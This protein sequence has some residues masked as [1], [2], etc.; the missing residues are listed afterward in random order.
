[1]DWQDAYAVTPAGTHISFT[2]KP[3]MLT[4]DDIIFL[5]RYSGPKDNSVDAVIVHKGIHEVIDW[6]QQLKPSNYTTHAL[7]LE[8][9][10]RAEILAETLRG[11]FPHSA[12]FWRDAYYNGK[13]AEL[14]AINNKLGPII[15]AIFSQQGFQVLPGHHVSKNSN[16]EYDGVHPHN[17]VGNVMISMIASVL[18]P[19]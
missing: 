16:M 15:K 2:W 1:M 10:A 17:S 5:K 13:D 7:E 18:C 6:Q 14:E 9:S 3:E 12:L 8:I 19:D 4:A 11:R